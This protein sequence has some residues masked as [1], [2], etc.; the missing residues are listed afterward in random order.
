MSRVIAIFK[1]DAAHL[2]KQILIFLATMILFLLEDPMYVE[3]EVWSTDLINLLYFLL[4][5]SG[6]LLVTSVIQEEKPIGQ[7]Q[8]WLTRPVAVRDLVAAK[9]LFLLA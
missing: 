7:Q 2:R 3:H 5:L 6:W 8:Y 9:A 1:K 4:P